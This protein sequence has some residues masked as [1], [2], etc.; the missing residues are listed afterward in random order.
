M[1]TCVRACAWVCAC[2]A[3]RFQAGGWPPGA[4]AVVVEVA[5]TA[6]VSTFS[7]LA[8]VV[9]VVGS[10]PFQLCEHGVVSFAVALQKAGAS[11]GTAH[12]FLLAG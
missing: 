2:A 8:R 12:V 3:V 4:A 10:L 9:V 1:R 7:F 5:T 6:A 11:H